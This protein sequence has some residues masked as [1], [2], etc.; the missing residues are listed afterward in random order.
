MPKPREGDSR[1]A[2]QDSAA[3]PTVKEWPAEERQAAEKAA[4]E[5]LHQHMESVPWSAIQ[6]V[7]MIGLEKIALIE[8][9]SELT[10][11]LGGANDDRDH[12][13]KLVVYLRYALEHERDQTGAHKSIT[14]RALAKSEHIPDLATCDR[15]READEAALATTDQGSG[16]G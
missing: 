8:R 10:E 1:S 12:L 16:D 14:E 15:L 6:A 3:P 13:R 2:S 5:L 7:A 4:Q 11:A 9:V